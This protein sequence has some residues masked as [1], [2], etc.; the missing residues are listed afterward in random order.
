MGQK[1]RYVCSGDG[2]SAQKFKQTASSG[3]VEAELTPLIHF[4][5]S[6]P[7]WTAVPPTSRVP[8]KEDRAGR[9]LSVN[10]PHPGSGSWGGT[11]KRMD[12]SLIWKKSCF[13]P[14][15]VDLTSG[16]TPDVTQTAVL[17]HQAVHVEHCCWWEKRLNE[18]RT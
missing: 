11:G 12:C 1:R 10:T 5:S 14:G 2:D 8:N 6:E 17:R 3:R 15:F 18:M 4:P 16:M 13:F 7:R 9:A